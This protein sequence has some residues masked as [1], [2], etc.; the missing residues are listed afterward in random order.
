MGPAAHRAQRR[1]GGRGPGLAVGA[2]GLGCRAAGKEEGERRLLLVVLFAVQFPIPEVAAGGEG[3][4]TRRALQTLLVPG[5]LV[6]SHQEAVGDGPL[7][8]LADGGMRAVGACSAQGESRAV[9]AD[10]PNPSVPAAGYPQPRRQGRGQPGSAAR[11]QGS[12]GRCARARRQP[13]LLVLVRRLGRGVSAGLEA[14]LGAALSP[15][16]EIQRLVLTRMRTS[17]ARGSRVGPTQ[18]R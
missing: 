4:L 14:W 16:P 10:Q 18:A 6:D 5:R 13:Q 12:P 7:A 3:L 15:S 8:A 2:A 17:A 11:R 9:S 1:P